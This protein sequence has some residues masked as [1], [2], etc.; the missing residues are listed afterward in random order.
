MTGTDGDQETADGSSTQALFLAVVVFVTFGV[1]LFVISRYG[2]AGLSRQ[3]DALIGCLSVV[4]VS[5]GNVL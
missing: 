5:V 2:P 3:A 1:A 4:P